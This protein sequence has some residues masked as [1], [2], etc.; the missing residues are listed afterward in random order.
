MAYPDRHI[1]TLEDVFPRVVDTEAT[2]HTPGHPGLNLTL[3]FR[4]AS[5]A[6]RPRTG[7]LTGICDL[8]YGREA[9]QEPPEV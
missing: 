9:H 6:H 4:P 2:Y 8:A 5:Y 3:A 1:L 7:L